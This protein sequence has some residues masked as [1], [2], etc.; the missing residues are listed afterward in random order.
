[1]NTIQ[2]LSDFVLSLSILVAASFTIEI[3]IS[4]NVRKQIHLVLLLLSIA[5]YSSA[6]YI[7]YHTNNSIEQH[8]SGIAGVIAAASAVWFFFRFPN[9]H[10]KSTRW[11]K[12]Y[13]AFGVPM[14][15][16]AI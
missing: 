10:R 14:L 8:L 2:A 11:L 4:G 7:H 6:T 16:L 1:M 5:L 3:V 13:T 12:I 15:A 9:Y